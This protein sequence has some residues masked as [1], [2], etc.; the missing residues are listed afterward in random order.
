MQETTLSAR[1]G[2]LSSEDDDGRDDSKT[3]KPS[4]LT[5]DI[6]A[7]LRRFSISAP[8]LAVALPL[9][10]VFIIAVAVLSRS[11]PHAEILVTPL[12]SLPL[13]PLLPG[14]GLEGLAPNFG[15]LGVPL[16]KPCLFFSDLILM[17][18]CPSL[19]MFDLCFIFF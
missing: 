14:N 1:R 4:R 16:C 17:T 13:V 2:A 5:M 3:K 10:L 6:L 15:S 19:R 9:L 11:R 12:D 8:C 18:V 7:H